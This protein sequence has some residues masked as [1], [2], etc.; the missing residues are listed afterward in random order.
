MADTCEVCGGV[1]SNE[2]GPN[3]KQEEADIHAMPDTCVDYLLDRIGTLQAELRRFGGHKVSCRYWLTHK[4]EC[5]CGWT[6]VV[7]KTGDS[8]G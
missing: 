3:R 7:T 5:S 4:S 1:L 2:R 6:E 8:D